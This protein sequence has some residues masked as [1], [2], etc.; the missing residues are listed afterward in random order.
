MDPEWTHECEMTTRSII[1]FEE[2]DVLQGAR[3]LLAAVWREA[4]LDSL[5]VSTWVA[6]SE[7]PQTLML[8]DPDALEDADPFAP[9]M[10]T[11]NAGKAAQI[12]LQNKVKRIG[13]FL[14]PCELRSFHSLVGP[15]DLDPTRCLLVSSDCLG[16]YPDEDFHWRAA[17]IND[18]ESLT[19][20]SLRFSVQGGI[21]P[22][23]N[24][25]GCQLCDSPSP[26]G[27]DVQIGLFGLESGDQ[28][29]V[30]F[31]EQALAKKTIR[32]F[33]TIPVAQEIVERRSRLLEDITTWRRQ[34]LVRETE[35]LSPEDLNEE[36]L[37]EHLASCQSCSQRLNDHCPGFVGSQIPAAMD[38]QRMQDWIGSCGGCGICEHLCPH[39]F[40]L[41]EVIRQLNFRSQLESTNGGQPPP[42]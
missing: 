37:L 35:I 23:R 31:R 29:M 21:L 17:T 7:T 18:P 26:I 2:I 11:N 27:A 22:S 1:A 41:F 34:S 15:N 36:A 12:H 14:R 39:G 20:Q 38:I 9:V 25:H 33:G 28:L 42:L 19:L 13:Y 6:G 24:R 32:K 16:V 4:A 8:E 10:R 5:L 30:D 40:P 3:E